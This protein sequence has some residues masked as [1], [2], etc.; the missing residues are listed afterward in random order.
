MLAVSIFLEACC[1]FSTL[2][3]DVSVSLEVS[4][5]DIDPAESCLVVGNKDNASPSVD[6]F[7]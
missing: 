5:A 3:V 1:L 4:E 2:P 6:F 7:L